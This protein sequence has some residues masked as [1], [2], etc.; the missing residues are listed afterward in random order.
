MPPQQA[1]G[2][3]DFVDNILDFGPHDPASCALYGMCAVNSDAC[4][5]CKDRQASANGKDGVKTARWS[6]D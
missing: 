6:R 3:L 4:R 5:L 1:Y 2:L